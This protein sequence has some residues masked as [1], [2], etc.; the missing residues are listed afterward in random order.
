M[1]II[2]THLQTFR[3][4]SVKLLPTGYHLYGHL[5]Y[6]SGCALGAVLTFPPQRPEKL[7]IAK[8]TI[9]LHQIRLCGLSSENYHWPDLNQG[10]LGDPGCWH[11]DV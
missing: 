10:L 4:S 8:Q 5:I 11:R 7:V 1:T 6:I 2:L 3:K 9:R